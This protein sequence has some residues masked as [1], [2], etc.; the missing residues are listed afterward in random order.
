MEVSVKHE[1]VSDSQ[2]PPALEDEVRPGGP[3]A[4]VQLRGAGGDGDDT[5]GSGQDHVE[6]DSSVT[7]GV[8]VH[9]G[10]DIDRLEHYGSGAATLYGDDDTDLLFSG[11]AAATIYGNAGHDQI[12]AGGGADSVYAGDDD[13]TVLWTAGDGTDAVLEGGAGTDHLVIYLTDGDDEVEIT[14]SSGVQ[15]RINR[16]S[17]GSLIEHLTVDSGFENLT[18]D[19][20]RG[21]DDITVRYLS[22]ANLSGVTLDLGDG[23]PHDSS[24]DHVLLEGGAGV[25]TFD[26][27][28]NSGEVTVLHVGVT[29][30]TIQSPNRSTG[31]AL[32]IDAKGGADS[33][34]AAAVAQDLLAI[35]LIGGANNDTVIGSPYDD[36]L[37]S[38]S[39][40][41]TVTG[42][43]GVDVFI[44][45]SGTDTL[46]ETRDADM[47]LTD[48]AFVVG[49]IQSDTGGTFP[50]SAIPTGPDPVNAPL[51]DEAHRYAPGAEFESLNGIFEVATL[52]GGASNNMFVIGDRDGQ[53]YV[54]TTAHSVAH[55]WT[56]SA[57]LDNAANSDALVE[58]YIVNLTGTGG[59]G[60]AVT[61][62]GSGDYDELYVVGTSGSETFRITD[63]PSVDPTDG[64]VTVG[65]PASSDAD[66]INHSAVNQV[67]IDALGAG[68]TINV[69]D[70]VIPT[71]IHAGAGNAAP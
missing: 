14:K 67:T 62:S 44:D 61:D 27:S 13:D 15:F 56:G 47:T 31:D 23:S 65:D 36:T 41:D 63:D 12:T 30:F 49:T 35:E 54:G 2:V 16:R 50:K 71:A 26:I 68:D 40:N 29:E 46:V 32:T 28:T 6:I 18:V 55:S 66:I 9:G 53:I 43:E 69:R 24:A 34:N 70:T 25:D 64:I 7:V 51:S 60:I 59:A 38:G 20:A 19:A 11:A 5:G 22:G 3:G 17:S 52:T 42:G 33:L 48:D 57:T 1:G 58:Y 45:P 37:N 8:T 21:A 4:T 10:A 39:G